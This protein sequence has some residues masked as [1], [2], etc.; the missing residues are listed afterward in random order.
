MGDGLYKTSNETF[1]IAQQATENEALNERSASDSK[2]KE[3]NKNFLVLM[4][5][6]FG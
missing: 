5:E 4:S 2:R 6:N 1:N 3:A